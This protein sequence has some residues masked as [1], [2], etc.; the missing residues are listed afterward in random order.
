MAGTHHSKIHTQIL[1][2]PSWQ[3]NWTCGSHYPQV[4]PQ[5]YSWVPVEDPDSCPALVLPGYFINPYIPTAHICSHI[6]Y[7]QLHPPVHQLQHHTLHTELAC[8]RAG[9]HMRACPPRLVCTWR[10]PTLKWRMKL[11]PSGCIVKLGYHKGKGSVGLWGACRY[12][13]KRCFGPMVLK[14]FWAKAAWDYV[15]VFCCHFF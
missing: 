5:V 3:V 9:H 6:G 10:R 12:Y 11:L 13:G 1:S 14:K 4:F 15:T 8:Q 7:E 2:D